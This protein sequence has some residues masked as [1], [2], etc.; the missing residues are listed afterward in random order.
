MTTDNQS[1]ETMMHELEEIVKQL[2][3]DTIS[4]EESLALYQ[5][6]IA[7]SKACEKTLKEAENKVSKLIE[8]EADDVNESKSE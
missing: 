5:K 2:D 3:N 4:L 7:L 8:D 6:G 1:F